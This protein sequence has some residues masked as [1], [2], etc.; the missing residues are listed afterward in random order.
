[1]LIEN[2]YTL[3][4]PDELSTREKDDAMGAYMMMFASVAIG[5]PLPILNLVASFIYYMINKKKSRFVAFH[6]LQ[7]MLSSLGIN[8]IN[9]VAVIWIIILF[10]S[11]D[12][13]FTKDFMVFGILAIILNIVYFIVSLISTVKAKRGEF[14]YIFFFGKF[15]YDRIFRIKESEKKDN[16]NLPP[17]L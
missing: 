8:I 5:M 1:M 4:Q 13:N 16:V 6:S 17:G 9:T 11:N 7:A 2:Y 14:Y 15:C 12:F 10:I 3:P